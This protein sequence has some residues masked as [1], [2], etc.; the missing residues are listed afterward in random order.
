MPCACVMVAG[1]T[2][3]AA[4]AP[5]EHA[6]VLTAPLLRPPTQPTSRSQG[7][8]S[9]PYSKAHE[10]SKRPSTQFLEG[11]LDTMC[12]RAL[13]APTPVIFQ[14]ITPFADPFRRNTSLEIEND[15]AVTII[16]LT[17]R[18]WSLSRQCGSACNPPSL[19]AALM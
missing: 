10:A 12:H 17:T 4:A 1:H 14:K 6:A 7:D 2:S 9:Q 18:F 3:Q 19:T 13:C 15:Q 8:F 5:A 11:S 16:L